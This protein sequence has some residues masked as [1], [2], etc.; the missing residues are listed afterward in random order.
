M[1]HVAVVVGFLTLFLGVLSAP[2][3]ADSV[4]IQYT[5]TGTFGPDVNAAPLSG[6]QGAYSM[7]F[8][9]PS[10]PTPDYF[11]TT[12]GNFATF[13]VPVSYSFQCNGCSQTATFQGTAED[14]DFATSATGGLF[15][16]EFL[17]DG[18]DYYFEFL[19]DQLFT[20]PV[21]SPTLLLGGPHQASFNGRFE[22]DNHDFVSLGTATVDA[23]AVATPE[24]ST[25]ALMVAALAS[26]GLLAWFKAQ[27]G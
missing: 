18:H 6:P 11:M 16:V 5:I 17:T 7:S 12:P 4:Q 1:R 22:L 10:N 25:L 2:A 19:G 21:D 20:G 3:R 24:P 23:T 13:N 15:V 27:R 26:L 14:V 8:E 9:L